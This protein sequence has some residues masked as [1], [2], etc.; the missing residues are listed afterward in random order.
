[1]EHLLDSKTRERAKDRMISTPWLGFDHDTSQQFDPVFLSEYPIVRGWTTEQLEAIRTQQKLPERQTL[2]FLQSFLFFGA[3]ESAYSCSFA[4]VDFVV[5]RDGI[6]FLDTSELRNFLECFALSFKEKVNRDQDLAAAAYFNIRETLKVFRGWSTFLQTASLFVPDIDAAVMSEFD[7]VY[8]A[9]NVLGETIQESSKACKS[10]LKDISPAQMASSSIPQYGWEICDRNERFYRNRLK[11][12]GWCPSLYTDIIRLGLSTLQVASVLDSGDARNHTNCKNQLCIASN[13]DLETYELQHREKDCK[14]STIP[15]PVEHMKRILHN[16]K[17]PLINGAYIMD[18]G[19][20]PEDRVVQWEPG[21]KFLTFSH[22]WSDGLGSTTEKGLPRCQMEFLWSHAIGVQSGMS[23]L[24]DK[25]LFWIDA[26][27]IPEDDSLRKR[28]IGL[29]AEIFENSSVTIVLDSNLTEFD[30]QG[31]SAEEVML[32]LALAP[33]NRRLWTLQEG[34]LSRNLFYQMSRAVVSSAALLAAAEDSVP[35]A[36]ITFPTRALARFHAFDKR[37]S[38]R[39]ETKYTLGT[40]VNMLHGRTSSKPS[41]ETLAIA[42][43]VRRDP[44]ELYSLAGEARMGAFFRLLR[45]VNQDILFFSR[46][47]LAEKGL[48]WAPKTFLTQECRSIHED[49]PDCVICKDGL[50]GDFLFLRFPQPIYFGLDTSYLAVDDTGVS[51]RFGIFP[52]ER[53]KVKPFM[54]DALIVQKKPTVFESLH[55]AAAVY[56]VSD[57]GG[58]EPTIP[59]YHYQEHIFIMVDK[60]KFPSPLP[61]DSRE[62]FILM[63]Q[64]F[65]VIPGS[66]FEKSFAVID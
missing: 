42:A 54:C 41:D 40:I 18:E 48:R 62:G 34:L 13:I 30:F 2:A 17:I 7:K 36:A 45:K 65:I 51:Y 22:V 23:D 56:K 39:K 26:L 21:V 57:L 31:R 49:P 46:D 60:Y 3:L 33:W 55:N 15:L 32:R 1:M 35:T 38:F 43:L 37:E 64:G 61:E 63:P 24:C 10:C 47:R 4:S 6:Q 25:A 66:T 29:M 8:A 20:K 59:V 19:A 27:C 50:M 16:G 5:S 12:R 58:I 28:A 14:C 9:L 52:S 53:I 44:S 11:E